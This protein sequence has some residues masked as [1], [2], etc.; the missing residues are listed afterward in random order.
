MKPV[1]RKWIAGALATA[2]TVVYA[3]PPV[4]I[5]PVRAKMNPVIRPYFAPSVPEV[6][7]GNSARL[8]S[9]M[10][11]GALYLTAQDAVALAIENNIDLEVARYNPLIADWN[12]ER[13]QAGGALPGVPSGASQA[14]SVAAGQGVQGSQ[15]A[16]G[17]A[18]GGGAGSTR[19]STNASV[20]QIGPVVQTLDPIIQQTSSFSHKST[21]QSNTTQSSVSN[22][23]DDSRAYTTSYQQGYL[24][25]GQVTL[26]TTENYL[27][28]NSP[29]DVLNPSYAPTL[30]VGFQQALLRG[31]RRRGQRS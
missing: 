18:G 30:S 19:G 28:E 29:T 10:R 23:I 5:E 16:A 4:S 21:P 14:G 17:V 26:T 13:A 31:I 15:S 7:V 27:K 24:L 8:K 12:L 11:A 22:L 25:G 3:Q 9:L 2:V 1:F 20:T 6:R